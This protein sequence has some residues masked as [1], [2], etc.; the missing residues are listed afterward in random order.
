MTPTDCAAF[1]NAWQLQAT[2][3]N[4]ELENL[5]TSSLTSVGSTIMQTGVE[6]T[7]NSLY[8]LMGKLWDSAKKY[9][10]KLKIVQAYSTGVYTHRL[11]II[12]HFSKRAIASGYWN[13]DIKTNFA[14]GYTNGENGGDS[15][16][17]MWEQNP[18][19]S[20]TT[21]YEGS[22]VLDFEAPTMYLDKLENAFR[23]VGEFRTFINGCMTTFESDME[24]YQENFNRE[25][26]CSAIAQDI[27]QES[28]RPESI[29]HIITEF[30]RAFGTSYSETDLL[31]TY[32]RDFYSF[33][34]QRLTNVIDRLEERSVLFH[35]NPA[36]T[37]NG[38]E[39]DLLRHTDRNE[40]K[41]VCYAPT[42]NSL[43]TYVLPEIFH[44]EE[45][46][47][48]TSKFEKVTYWQNINEPDSI[49]ITPAVVD[50]D[51]ESATYGKPI[52]GER[53]RA[54]PLLYI[55]HERRIMTDQQFKRALSSPVEAR[56]GY[57]NVFHH[58]SF[59]HVSD[60]TMPSV[61]VIL[62]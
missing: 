34:A 17:S 10:G 51:S 16:K 39:Y 6:N 37:V 42:F 49:D 2:G 3:K 48:D 41:W 32:C 40:L 25:Q 57:Y 31:T 44:S 35:W 1:A 13:T 33:L 30:N 24:Q 7:I 22:N 4:P 56:K 12:S 11:G 52:V 46:K 29:I 8:I 47:I 20:M 18:D 9:N 62:D 60:I 15:T 23:N 28:D 36:K 43:Q 27:D 54:K 38:V 50:T 55:F 19:V 26:L 21:F 59:N 5:D 45:L 58:W 61:A 14:P 53:V